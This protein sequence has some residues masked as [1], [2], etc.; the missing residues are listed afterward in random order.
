MKKI[1]SYLTAA[2]LVCANFTAVSAKYD[3]IDGGLT[4]KE[5]YEKYMEENPIPNKDND[6]LIKLRDK[7]VG[8]DTTI[9]KPSSGNMSDSD[10]S[11]ESS[12]TIDMDKDKPFDEILSEKLKLDELK[13]TL[14]SASAKNKTAVLRAESSADINNVVVEL[15]RNVNV[16]YA[17][18]DYKVKTMSEFN[19][20]QW[21]IQNGGQTI[22]SKTGES[23]F[24]MKIPDAWEITKGSEEVVVGIIDTGIDIYHPSIE[25]NIWTNNDETD[26]GADNDGNGYIDDINGW[27]FVNNDNK[28]Y[29]MDVVDMHGTHMAGIIAANGEI[30]GIAPKVKIMPLKALNYKGGY[31]SDI[32]KAIEYAKSKGVK[33]I[34]CSFSG[35]DRNP[36]LEEAMASNPDILFVCAAGNYGGP[37]TK[38]ATFPA[39]YELDNVISVSAANNKGQLWANSTYGSFIDVAAPGV[40][41]Y[42]ILPESKYGFMDGTSCSAAYVSGMAALLLSSNKD[43]T[44]NGLKNKIINSVDGVLPKQAEDEYT[45]VETEGMVNAYAAFEASDEDGKSG[46]IGY[47]DNPGQENLFVKYPFAF[48][49]QEGAVKFLLDTSKNITSV[50]LKIYQK[51]GE[52]EEII[53]TDG[54]VPIASEFVLPEFQTDVEYDLA[55]KTVIGNDTCE[56]T[57]KITQIMVEGTPYPDVNILHSQH[58]ETVAPTPTPPPAATGGGSRRHNNSKTNETTNNNTT[59]SN[60]NSDNAAENTDTENISSQNEQESNDT[61]ESANLTY[62]DCNNY[63]YISSINDVDYYKVK[64]AYGGVANFWLGDIPE[65]CDY[66]LYLYDEGGTLLAKSCNG[67]TVAELISYYPVSGEKYYYIK[68]AS[69]SGY[70]AQSAYMV[71]TKLYDTPSTY[72]PNDSLSDAYTL[73]SANQIIRDTLFNSDDVDYYKVTLGQ[74]E[75]LEIKLIKPSSDYRF[76]VYNASNLYLSMTEITANKYACELDGGTYYIKIYTVGEYSSSRYTLTVTHSPIKTLVQGVT[77]DD[78][79]SGSGTVYYNL[80]ITTPKGLKFTLSNYGDADYDLYL[81]D[82]NYKLLDKSVNKDPEE[83]VVYI[84]QKG[85]YRIKVNRDSGTYASYRLT[86]EQ[87]TPTDNAYLTAATGYPAHM[88]ANDVTAVTIYAENTGA[89]TWT[90]ADGYGLA[91]LNQSNMFAPGDMS[92]SS[93]DSITYG[94]GKNFIFNITAP[95]VTI[96]THYTMD[97]Q[98]KH[99]ARYFGDKL[100]KGVL[101]TPYYETLP[102]NTMKTIAG[103]STTQRYI[104]NVASKG[105]YVFRTLKSTA[106][107]D[108]RLVLYDSSLKVVARND[109]AYTRNHYSKIEQNLDVGTYLID[110]EE[111]DGEPIFCNL[112]AERYTDE[113]IATDET[114]SIANV[115]EGYYKFNVSSAGTYVIK[116]EYLQKNS[117]TYLLLYNSSGKLIDENDNDSSNYSRIAKNLDEGTYYIRATTYDYIRKGENKK[118]FCKLTLSRGDSTPETAKQARINITYPTNGSVVKLYD[119]SALNIKGTMANVSGITVK[120][121]DET[122]SNVKTS[123]NMFSCTYNPS[124]NGEYSITV[125]GNPIYGGTAPTAA[126]RVNVLINDDGDTFDTATVIHEGIERA[127]SI[128]HGMDIDIFM[129][130]P[131]QSGQYSIHTTGD[132][133]TTITVYNANYTMINYNDDDFTERLSSNADVPMYMEKGNTYYILVCCFSA[134]DMGDYKLCVNML[135]DDNTSGRVLTLGRALKG[136]IDYPMDEDLYIFTPTETREYTFRTIGSGDMMGLVY[137]DNQT[138]LEFNDNAS[139]TEFN[140]L[141]TVTLEAGRDYYFAVEDDRSYMYGNTYRVIVE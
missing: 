109:D 9:E 124:E 110:V 22:E 80:S 70:N 64:F 33:I 104:F 49:Y 31:T 19:E 72:E 140:C 69:V 96:D 60:V 85:I 54:S 121:N 93:T 6:I 134:T 90:L 136:T 58:Y 119:G 113:D 5:R 77:Y 56:Y 99:N 50:N 47:D 42:S 61:I 108:T 125:T 117:D 129:F 59:D 76:E 118:V 98:M 53:L 100:S 44:A 65:N 15:N 20:K 1:I 40:G 123:G 138:C 68:V 25:G 87:S 37:S 84:L 114:V 82:E 7:T 16:Q 55:I 23:G 14:V 63:G 94:K 133:D 34:N 2:A 78:T 97:W 91:A 89:K 86:S 18:K 17:Q 45:D 8:D 122:V 3:S 32:I 13:L 92:L 66:E 95:D 103:K 12:G 51:T 62:D 111:Y 73:S 120:V 126:A 46:D 48:R 39:C 30:S 75:L 106:N 27:D 127:A 128:D 137:D 24:D 67:G 112:Y 107:C 74:K 71:R 41:I 83:S 101:V 52:K 35:T 141:I 10:M 79:M 11:G 4:D 115:Y 36:A 26:D 139:E 21:A 29:D 130:K 88:T 38:L 43:L 116:T 135:D 105:N 131:K 28:V 57:G 132:I 102:L 81:Y